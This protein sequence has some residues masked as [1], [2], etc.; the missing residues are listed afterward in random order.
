M[1]QFSL[2]NSKINFCLF[3]YHHRLLCIF[4]SFFL[5]NRHLLDVTFIAFLPVGH[6]STSHLSSS[7][8]SSPLNF[9][10]FRQKG[11]YGPAKVVASLMEWA[12]C[13]KDSLKSCRIFFAHKKHFICFLCFALLYLHLAL[14][15]LVYMSVHSALKCHSSVSI[16]LLISGL[17]CNLLMAACICGWFPGW[18]G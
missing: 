10:T 3:Y 14:F 2:V 16:S 6:Y 11:I 7:S 4:F 13:V 1:S 17:R 15:F 8:S 5:F 12:S 9:I 18:E